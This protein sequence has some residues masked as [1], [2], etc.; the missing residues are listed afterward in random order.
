MFKY[1]K[2]QPVFL[3]ATANL[4]GLLTMAIFLRILS[5]SHRFYPQAARPGGSLG[6][7]ECDL[8][9]VTI[10]GRGALQVLIKD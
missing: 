9:P 1:K 6:M 10:E 2:G 3:R 8:P 7:L 4:R 5:H